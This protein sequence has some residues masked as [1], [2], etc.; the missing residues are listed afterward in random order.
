MAKDPWQLVNVA[1]NASADAF[2]PAMLA[3]LSS[4]LWDIATCTGASC[5]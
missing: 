3:A 4:E 5:P 2:S 1:H